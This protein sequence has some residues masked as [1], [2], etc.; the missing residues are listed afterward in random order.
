MYIFYSKRNLR[1]SSGTS[2]KPDSMEYW[3]HYSKRKKKKLFHIFFFGSILICIS[4]KENTMQYA[5][6]IHIF[7]SFKNCIFVT[8]YY[9]AIV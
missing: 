5:V 4:F 3:I 8:F 6:E 2:Q 7:F 9:Y 1:N